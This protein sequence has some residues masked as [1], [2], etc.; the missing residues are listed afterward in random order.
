MFLSALNGVNMLIWHSSL[1]HLFLSHVGSF[2]TP[3][4]RGDQNSMKV[5]SWEH[6]LSLDIRYA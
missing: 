1:Q 4:S 3:L 6:G 2:F 5:K